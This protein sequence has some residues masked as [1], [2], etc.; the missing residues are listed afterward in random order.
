MSFS[1]MA[2]AFSSWITVCLFDIVVY[3]RILRRGNIV[4]VEINLSLAHTLFGKS[5]RARL[6]VAHI[7]A[8]LLL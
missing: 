7:V 5:D 1:N 2:K 6:Y 8:A 4:D 3:L